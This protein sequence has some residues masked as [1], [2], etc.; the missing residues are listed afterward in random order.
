[1]NNNPAK[2]LSLENVLVVLPLTLLIISTFFSVHTEIIAGNIFYLCIACYFGVSVYRRHPR[3]E[4]PTAFM[5]TFFAY[6]ITLAMSML[7]SHSP[8]QGWIILRRELT[9]LG[10]PIAFCTIHISASNWERII[11]IFFRTALLFAT[12]T[13]IYWLYYI[14]LNN[15]DIQ[16]FFIPVKHHIANINCWQIVYGWNSYQHPSYNALGLCL[17]LIC[18]WWLLRHRSISVIEA[19]VYA[20]LAGLIVYI[21]Q[22]RIGIVMYAAIVLTCPLLMVWENKKHRLIYIMVLFLF[23]I[24]TLVAWLNISTPFS[25]DKARHVLYADAIEGIKAHPIL[26]VGLGGLPEAINNAKLSNPHN[27]LLGDWLQSGLPAVCALTVMILTLLWNALSK[28][29][30]V[31][32][33]FIVIS[34]LFMQIEMPF[35]LI[36]GINYFV[37]FACL[38]A[39]KPMASKR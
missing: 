19:V 12:V 17:G 34:L 26:G 4:C 31:L 16:L 29:N 36:K 8:E 21:T 2:I 35:Y 24:V 10:I 7:W 3:Y 23:G 20:I 13:I 9:W 30:G 37:L 11:K 1:M 32:L 38:F 22:S 25:L 15:I 27:Q 5:W 14:T 18:C 6:F 33:L 28:R 39:A